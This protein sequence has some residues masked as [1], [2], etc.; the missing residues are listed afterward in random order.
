MHSRIVSPVKITPQIL[1]DMISKLTQLDVTCS[2]DES[3]NMYL[4]RVFMV[5]N[6]QKKS[7]RRTIYERIDSFAKNNHMDL[8]YSVQLYTEQ[9]TRQ[10]Y[11][12]RIPSTSPDFQD[13]SSIMPPLS[14]MDGKTK[15]KRFIK[16]EE[17]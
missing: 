2:Y 12:E 17:A 8:F 10:Y 7:L 1:A 3:E 15:R 16:L 14:Q 9:E 4:L 13:T 11:P 6:A 5:Q